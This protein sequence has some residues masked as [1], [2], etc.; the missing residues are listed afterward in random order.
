MILRQLM[1]I[2]TAIA[3][4][5]A[6]QA[7]ALACAC[8]SLVAQRTVEVMKIDKRIS[9]ELAK[10]RFRDAAKLVIDERYDEAIQGRTRPSRTSS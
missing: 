2:L 4:V 7:A 5:L 9:T 6:S 8:C 1:M 3:V 10:V